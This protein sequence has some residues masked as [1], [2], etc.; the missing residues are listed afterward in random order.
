M[1]CGIHVLH[2]EIHVHV[3]VVVA[4]IKNARVAPSYLVDHMYVLLER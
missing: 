3:D 4:Y 1:V 2:V